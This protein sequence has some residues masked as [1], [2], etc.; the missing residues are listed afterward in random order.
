MA[1]SSPRYQRW[2][3]FFS[4]LCGTAALGLATWGLLRVNP[5]VDLSLLLYEAAALLT[6]EPPR[7]PAD[8]SPHWALFWAR[9]M[10]LLFALFGVVGILLELYRPFSDLALRFRFWAARALLL[11]EQAVV[12]GLGW[13]GGQLAKELRQ[14][15]R[16]VVGT[17]LDEDSLA[18][19]E[20]RRRATLVIIGDSTDPLT[21]E[22]SGL[23]HASEV[24]IATGD[25]ARNV[26]IAGN[27]L[28]DA[29]APRR[30][31]LLGRWL[32]RLL[33]GEEEPRIGFRNA[34]NPLRCYV[35][36]GDPAL[37]TTLRRH[38][39]LKD[40]AGDV[41]VHFFSNREAAAGQ[42]F[43]EGDEHLIDAKDEPA[44]VGENPLERAR[45][46]ALRPA[47]APSP[48]EVLHLFVF[49]FG[50]T[51]QTV[52]LH[53]ARFAHFAGVKDGEAFRT[54]LTVIDAFGQP[55]RS[56]ERDCFLDRFPAFAPPDL[57]F[58][59]PAS[60][61]TGKE[62]VRGDREDGKRKASFFD[63]QEEGIAR[64]GW[65]ARPGRAGHEGFRMPR[66]VRLAY[67]PDAHGKLRDRIEEISDE[68][69]P[70]WRQADDDG[71]S[72]WVRPVEYAIN[73]EFLTL[74]SDVESP[75]IV[76]AILA[77]LTAEG[78][79]V[80]GA[81]VLCFEE[82]RESFHAAL[83]LRRALA[84][85]FPRFVNR[86]PS[87]ARPVLPIYVY[88]PVE[89]G[90]VELIANQDGSS[91]EERL[92]PLNGF[93]RQAEVNT[94]AAIT[95]R[96]VRRRARQIAS[97]H[98][99]LS[100]RRREK[101]RDFAA[102]NEESALHSRVKFAAL[103]VR[104]AREPIDGSG[105]GSG[106]RGQFPLLAGLVSQDV[107]RRH[108]RLEKQEAR[109]RKPEVEKFQR[110]QALRR[111][112]ER[113]ARKRQATGASLGSKDARYDDRIRFRPENPA[114]A[115]GNAVQPRG[116]LT[117]PDFAAD[118][119]VFGD[120]LSPELRQRLAL[121]D[122]VYIPPLPPLP[123][124]PSGRDETPEERAVRE[125]IE[126]RRKV[127]ER[128]D[129]DVREQA[130]A[131]ISRFGE[132]LQHANPDTDADV[133]AEME[134]NRWM[135]ERLTS[136]WRFGE[137]ADFQRP[138]LVPWD[139][140]TLESDLHYDRAHLPRLIL[141]QGPSALPVRPGERREEEELFAYVS[142][143]SSAAAETDT[144]PRAEAGVVLPVHGDDV[145][146]PARSPADTAAEGASQGARAVES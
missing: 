20:A 25:D 102:S 109:R 120:A 98:D 26:E 76:D 77:R 93:G 70:D 94:Y 45:G 51:G 58:D 81:A 47:Y 12:I 7:D 17:A 61:R 100:G 31:W 63:Y 69:P 123:E 141:E 90:L 14:K 2:F 95:R 122:R 82:E 115:P 125:A 11:Q 143:R 145:P 127:I 87:D 15:G 21:R 91:D 27:L 54:R 113:E 65:A 35:H 75:A 41:E 138:T 80:R 126:R 53:A 67:G 140:L 105:S 43:L 124:Q 29:R 86:D 23:R 62:R 137:K 3:L 119:P 55:A 16:P 84:Q 60:R 38:G 112:E 103:G 106:E 134:H 132:E 79:P 135:G 96:D 18:A 121:L 142:R 10:V 68:R 144:A 44:T 32:D 104:F 101:H 13:V 46:L 30:R 40:R 50:S 107:L 130:V 136:G 9:T 131:A 22:R 64:D 78:P 72:R 4:L 39:L 92:F 37:L 49:G 74:T 110:G 28:A 73:A 56:L 97:T 52:A 71:K 133:A 83:R 88:L 108:R 129:A 118:W 24:F 114:P 19:V 111:K 33:H 146:D 139:D 6:F 128:F 8:E 116:E 36:I 89:E 5:Y 99:I 34:E 59:S 117:S 1:R 66:Y 57:S 42:L 48:G 85:A